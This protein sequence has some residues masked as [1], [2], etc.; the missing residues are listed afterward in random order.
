MES[1]LRWGIEN[2]TS[3]TDASNPPPAPRQDLDPAIIDMILGKSDAELMKED[4]AVAKDESQSES[5][6]IDALDHLEMVRTVPS[7]KSRLSHP[8]SC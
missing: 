5:A 4:M 3:S 8:T 1:L 2:S 7:L 6:R